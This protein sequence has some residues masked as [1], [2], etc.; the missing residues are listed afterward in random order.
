MMT[1]THPQSQYVPYSGGVTMK[2]N[3]FGARAQHRVSLCFVIFLGF[4][5][6]NSRGKPESACDL[7]IVY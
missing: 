2:T 3:W 5:T 7:G 6:D 1:I 4:S